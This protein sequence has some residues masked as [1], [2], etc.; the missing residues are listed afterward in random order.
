M[1]VCLFLL[2]VCLF[3]C[4]FVG[5]DELGDPESASELGV[6]RNPKI[7]FVADSDYQDMRV[8]LDQQQIELQGLK[9]DLLPLSLVSKNEEIQ[10]GVVEGLEVDL[11]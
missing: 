11:N 7:A 3:V 2:F 9:G 1:F 10:P 8:G 6:V 5:T 4:L